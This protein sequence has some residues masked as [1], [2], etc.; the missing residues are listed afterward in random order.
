MSELY[1]GKST[2]P[3]ERERERERG[4]ECRRRRGGRRR[5]PPHPPDQRASAHTLSL[6]QPSHSLPPFVRPPR[7]I[8]PAGSTATDRPSEERMAEIYRTKTREAHAF[9]K[10][11]SE[12]KKRRTKNTHTHKLQ[13][14]SRRLQGLGPKRTFTFLLCSMTSCIHSHCH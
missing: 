12:E 5:W 7:R 3:R 9:K 6:D 10:K 14:R 13:E 8:H 11:K 2:G 1:V 4:R